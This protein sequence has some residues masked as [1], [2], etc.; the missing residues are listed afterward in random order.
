ML[1]VIVLTPADW[2]QLRALRLAGLAEAPAAFG[3]ALAEWT[4]KGDT[5][6]RWR[7]RLSSVP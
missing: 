1:E 4:G 5:E 6:H 2:C 3:S 7:A